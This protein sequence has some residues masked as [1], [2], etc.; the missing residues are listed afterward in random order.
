MERER[1]LV[2]SPVEIRGFIAYLS[3]ARTED[4]H[5][6]ENSGDAPAHV[7]V[8]VRPELENG[9]GIAHGGIGVLAGFVAWDLNTIRNWPYFAAIVAGIS[10]PT[11]SR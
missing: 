2:C 9:L 6:F 3:S 11:L 7:R 10:G 8:E 5:R 4:G 1:H